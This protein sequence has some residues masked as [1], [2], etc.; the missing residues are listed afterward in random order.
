MALWAAMATLGGA[1]DE[2]GVRASLDRTQVVMG[3]HLEM[4]VVVDGG[5]GSAPTMPATPDFDVVGSGKSTQMSLAG[6]RMHTQTS[7]KMQLAPRTP[8]RF[9]IGSAR[10]EIGGVVYQSAPIEVQVVAAQEPPPRA[11]T[12]DDQR[13]FLRAEVSNLAP[14]LGEPLIYSWRFY[15]LVEVH[16]AG[17]TLPNFSGFF[18]QSLGAQ[19]DYTTNLDGRAYRVTEITYALVPEEVGEQLVQGSN[20][21]CEVPIDA[22]RGGGGTHAFGP[23]GGFFGHGRTQPQVLHS[24]PLP[25]RVRPLPEPA[26]SGFAGLVGVYEVEAQLAHSSLKVGDSTTL[27]VRVHGRGLAQNVVEPAW[28]P[29]SGLR[30]YDD[31]PVVEASPKGE[32]LGGGKTF[33]K[34]LVAAAPG[35]FEVGPFVLVFFD[36]ETG[37]YRS[38]HAGPLALTVSGEPSE[39]AGP[40][41]AA[42]RGGHKAHVEVLADDIQPNVADPAILREGRPGLLEARQLGLALGAPPVAL[43]LMAGLQALRRRQMGPGRQRARGARRRGQKEVAQVAALLAGNRRLEAADMASRSLR[44]F[45]DARSGV[46]GLAST[47]EEVGAQLRGLGVPAALVSSA[48][49]FLSR[50]EAARFAVPGGDDAGAGPQGDLDQALA[51]QLTALDAA[52]PRRRPR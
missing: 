12:A 22:G 45:L 27:S 50:C 25:V 1:N 29:A 32:P 13:M 16:N 21:H 47:P 7:Y 9:S 40:A 33:R 2:R 35:R 17:L 6:G 14:W 15:R 19:R 3:D 28:T 48:E 10:V 24:P 30:A 36:P 4:T 49:A 23:F 5:L 42:P 18:S 43:G 41:A 37:D 51:S 11:D 20:L 44:H 34:A 39:T 26:P 8:G 38:A 31:R 46:A 52:L